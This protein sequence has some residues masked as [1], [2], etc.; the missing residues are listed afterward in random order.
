MTDVG[1]PIVTHPTAGAETMRVAA[2]PRRGAE[3]IIAAP[4]G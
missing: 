3:L 4:A 2:S 1:P